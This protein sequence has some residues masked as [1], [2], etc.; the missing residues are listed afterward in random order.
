MIM[1]KRKRKHTIMR[2]LKKHKKSSFCVHEDKKGGSGLMFTYD[3]KVECCK[4]G[5]KFKYAIK[6]D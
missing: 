2:W 4:C 3:G 6:V 5:A 1:N